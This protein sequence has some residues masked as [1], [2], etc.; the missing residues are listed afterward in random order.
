MLRVATV[1]AEVDATR[2]AIEHG[3][4][5]RVA[6]AAHDGRGEVTLDRLHGELHAVGRSQMGTEL[7]RPLADLWAP[8]GVES[9]RER[10]GVE[11]TDGNRLRPRARLRDN[12]APEELIAEEGHHDGRKTGA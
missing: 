12:A 7:A 2:V 3:Q 1:L 6:R 9:R 4:M 10:L 11:A 5:I 8:T